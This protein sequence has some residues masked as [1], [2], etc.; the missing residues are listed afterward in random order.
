MREKVKAYDITEE[1]HEGKRS[2]GTPTHRRNC[3]LKTQD[4]CGSPDPGSPV[5]M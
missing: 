3:I 5:S 2:F 4:T 1:N